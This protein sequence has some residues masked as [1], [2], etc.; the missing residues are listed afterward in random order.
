M[1]IQ[2]DNRNA[3]FLG[4]IRA[5]YKISLWSDIKDGERVHL[6]STVRKVAHGVGYPGSPVQETGLS[7]T[8]VRPKVYLLRMSAYT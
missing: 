6:F 2:A 4:Q 7:L 1:H 8:Q 3:R 5:R